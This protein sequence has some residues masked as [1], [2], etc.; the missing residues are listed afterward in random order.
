[1]SRDALREE[2]E[3]LQRAT[4][5]ARRH[6]LTGSLTA[7][8]R[9]MQTVMDDYLA[10]RAAGLSRM[11]AVRGIEAELRSVWPHRQTK[12]GP[13]CDACEDIGWREQT[14]WADHRCGRASCANGHPG[15]EHL[16]VV[17]CECPKGDVRAGRG[18][19]T[20]DAVADAMRTTRK[21]RR[22]SFSRW[23]GAA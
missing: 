10:A 22:S 19:A 1:M 13:Q 5:D 2:H 14:C 20:P 6:V 17:A 11:D 21:P 16:Y 9:K 4:Q 18:M 8:V 23:G 12:F 15:Y 3:S 7:F